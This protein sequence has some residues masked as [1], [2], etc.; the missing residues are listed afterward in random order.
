[1][2]PGVHERE[3]EEK[4][5]EKASGDLEST[6]HMTPLTQTHMRAPAYLNSNWIEGSQSGGITCKNR[7]VTV[8][9]SF[10]WVDQRK[11]WL[12]RRGTS[13]DRILPPTGFIGQD[14]FQGL[15]GICQTVQDLPSPGHETSE[16]DRLRNIKHR[17]RLEDL[18]ALAAHGDIKDLVPDESDGPD[19]RH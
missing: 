13:L 5:E 1:M 14:P 8:G 17:P 3:R 11:S 4:A 16:I 19:G 2:Q 18:R 6:S 15:G 9:R 7:S 12:G 10:R